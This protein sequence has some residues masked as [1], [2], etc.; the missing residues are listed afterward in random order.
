MFDPRQRQ[1]IF[2]LA[3]VQTGS[4]PQPASCTK[5]TGGGV[6]SPGTKR[7]RGVTL[8]IYPIQCRGRE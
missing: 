8:A 6:L 4:G 2:L 7:G 5:G 3:C 1:R